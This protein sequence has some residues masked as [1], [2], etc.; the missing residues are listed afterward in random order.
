[1]KVEDCFYFAKLGKAKGFKGEQHLIIDKETPFTP[2]ELKE[3]WVLVGKKLVSYPLSK[4]R[5]NPKNNADIQVTG[6][7]TDEDVERVKN[8][9]VYL[10]KTM[11]PELDEED[12][13][14]H[15]L[16]EVEIH[17]DKLGFIGVINEVNSQTAQ[18]LL[19]V[20]TKKDEVMIPLVDAF[21]IKLDKKENKLFTNLPEGILDL[22]E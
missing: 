16:V 15:E 17:D 3:V 9:G 21:V 13:Y 20:T 22:N 14:L 1:M 19:Y 4:Y 2:N 10:P 11:L 7:N 6:F 18:T 8:M 12:Y 5:L